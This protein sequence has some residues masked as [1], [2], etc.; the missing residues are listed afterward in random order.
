MERER[1]EPPLEAGLLVSLGAP[2]IGCPG[3]KGC[4]TKHCT[5]TA[6]ELTTGVLSAL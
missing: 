4:P 2:Y 3:D 6:T 5:Y 1:S